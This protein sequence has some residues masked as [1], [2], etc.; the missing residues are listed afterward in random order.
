MRFIIPQMY[1]LKLTPHE[2]TPE[3]FGFAFEEVHFPTKNDRSLYGWWIPAD[4]EMEQRPTLIL[5][6]GWK[7]NLGRMLRYIEHLHPLNY[8]LLAFDARHHG[9]SDEDGHGSM[10]K[11]GQDVK[12]AVDYVKTRSIDLDRIG[13]IGLSI[14]GAGSIYAASLEPAIKAVATVGAPAHPVDVMRRDFQKKH[15]PAIFIWYVLRMIESRIGISYEEFA[16][17][18]NIARAR[19]AFLIIHGE[20]DKVVLPSQGEKLKQAA[21]EN[22]CECWSIP[23]YGHS[24]C[25]HHKDFW[26]RVHRFFQEKLPAPALKTP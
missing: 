25:H 15:F 2:E 11:F 17:V 9:S 5:V 10:Y 6:H 24:N 4:T 21:R 19:A 8:N 12:S 1:A 16:P 13:V 7:R 22:Q 20:M 3:K 26:E 14:G 23:N 18:N